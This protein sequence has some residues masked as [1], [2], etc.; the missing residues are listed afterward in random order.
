MGFQHTNPLSGKDAVSFPNNMIPS[1]FVHPYFAPNAFWFWENR[2]SY[3]GTLNRDL[4]KYAQHIWYQPE[5]GIAM[6]N[7]NTVYNHFRLSLNWDVSRWLRL[8]AAA[9]ALLSRAYNLGVGY[10]FLELR[11]P[12]RY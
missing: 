6:D 12:P 8:G 4:F 9:D 5:Y 7:R 10:A 11:W 3:R 1:G 2:L